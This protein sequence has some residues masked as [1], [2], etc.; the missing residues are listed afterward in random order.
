[1]TE[2][3]DFKKFLDGFLKWPVLPSQEAQIIC[4]MMD[5]TINKQGAIQVLRY[6]IEENIKKHNEFVSMTKEQLLALFDEY[7]VKYDSGAN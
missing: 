5:G 1:M 7:G 6:I 4:A 2:A 3:D